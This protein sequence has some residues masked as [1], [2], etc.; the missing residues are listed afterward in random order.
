MPHT[1]STT[2]YASLYAAHR[3][4]VPAAYSAVFKQFTTGSNDS[5]CTCHAPTHRH[6][7]QNCP[8][9]VT[10]LHQCQ[11]HFDVSTTPPPGRVLDVACMNLLNCRLLQGTKGG[12]LLVL[13]PA[14]VDAFALLVLPLA[15]AAPSPLC[16]TSGLAAVLPSG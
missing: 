10:K 11:S 4:P 5:P 1:S 16:S 8:E 14:A 13:L 3:G 2:T 15:G 12:R 6:Q 9:L 7:R